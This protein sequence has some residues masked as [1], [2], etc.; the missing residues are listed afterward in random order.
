MAAAEAFVDAGGT[1]DAGNEALR[2][3]LHK[4]AGSAGLFGQAALGSEASA[5]EDA[6]EAAPAG[7]RAA[8]AGDFLATLRAAA[9]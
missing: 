3:L 6:L 4:F 5:L 9:D 7:K 2:G 1:D 8:L